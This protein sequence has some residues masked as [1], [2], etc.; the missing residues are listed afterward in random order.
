MFAY[1]VRG[2]RKLL[3]EKTDDFHFN[4]LGTSH[5]LSP[6]ENEDRHFVQLMDKDI[7]QSVASLDDIFTS[8]IEMRNS[9][10][11]LFTKS[12]DPDS[13]FA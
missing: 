7:C 2:L 1:R 10:H 11:F 13:H 9:P 6:I 4:P 5:S 8:H 3:C 12:T